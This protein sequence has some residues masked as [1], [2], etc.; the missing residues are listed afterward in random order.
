ME[1][2]IT[3]ADLGGNIVGVTVT[4]EIDLLASPYLRE[5][6][7]EAVGSGARGVLVDLS[8]ATFVDSTTLGVLMGAARRM[9][10]RDGVLTIV[11]DNASILTIFEITRL[12][13]VFDI[14]ASVNDAIT[15]L[16][17]VEEGSASGLISSADLP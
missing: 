5:S 15:H 1:F 11:C 12:D 9:R 4:G 17:E 3:S 16:A 14:F 10:D 8:K 6:L 2:G 7:V 13:R